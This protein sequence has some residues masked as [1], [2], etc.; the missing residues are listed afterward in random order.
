MTP[1]DYLYIFTMAKIALKN[2]RNRRLVRKAR[3]V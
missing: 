3:S 1:A 2:L